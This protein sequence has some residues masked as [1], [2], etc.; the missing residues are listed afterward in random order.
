MLPGTSVPPYDY[1]FPG[2]PYMNMND[3]P[4]PH[5]KTTSLKKYETE[6]FL[7]LVFWTVLDILD[8]L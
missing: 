3:P 6:A 7:K 2:Q 8:I 5:C 1:I 4:R